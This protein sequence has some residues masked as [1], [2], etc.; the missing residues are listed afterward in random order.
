MKKTAALLLLLARSASANDAEANPV[1]KVISLIEGMEKKVNAEVEETGS[2]YKEAKAFCEKR[3][4]DLAY[5]IKTG[6]SDKEE[7]EAKISKAESK[8][9]SMATAIEESMQTVETN[10][11][12]LKA[13]QDVRKGEASDFKSEERDL[14]ETMSNV[15]AAIGVVQRKDN[16]AAL[17]Q[18]QKAPDMLQALDVMVSAHMI[19]EQGAQGLTAFVQKAQSQN[20]E[21]QPAVAAYEKKNSGTVVE[22]LEDLYAKAKGEL[23][24]LRKKE[25]EAQAN[26]NMLSQSLNDGIEFAKKDAEKAKATSN[27]NESAKSDASKS[28]VETEKNL[29]SDTAEIKDLVRDCKKKAADY[30]AEQKD[31]A[32]ELEA[33]GVAKKALVEK[34][35]GGSE[36]VYSFEQEP[37]FLQLGS[38]VAATSSNSEVVRRLRRLAHAQGSKEISLLASRVGSVIR[39][40]GAF[41]TII[42]MIKEMVD[43]MQKALDGDTTKKAYCDKE[44]AKAKA[45]KEDKQDEVEKVTTRIEKATSNSASLKAQVKD[46]EKESV[47]LEK[48]IAEM[49]AVRAAEKKSF[50]KAKPELE[51]GLEGVKIALKVLRKYYEGKD[52]GTGVIGMLEVCEEDFAKSLSE[53]KIAEKTAE[54]DFNKESTEMKMEKQRK[55]A[56]IRFK[57]QEAARI[58]KDL[59]DLNGDAESLSTEMNAALEYEAGVQAECTESK[60]SFAEK[61]A[62][63]QAEIDGLKTAMSVLGDQDEAPA[64]AAKAFLQISRHQGNLRLGR[65]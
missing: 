54:E 22:M 11:G 48:S 57:T 39:S 42:K 10:E 15:E 28:L 51:A 30:D 55:S 64:E 7:L 58:D 8:I 6:K 2:V 23:V 29:K 52:K 16:G 46:L 32:D 24:A 26:F 20:S 27:E 12:E 34:A 33:L 25:A 31:N 36:E 45:K 19:S 60:E 14:L 17:L 18:V 41:D 50:E 49:Q 5:S 56:D 35:S 9:E 47:E 59:V 61:A 40:G 65:Y 37:S 38:K 43:R 4:N 44:M 62:K 1:A 63:R 3:S 53:R 13:A 21:F